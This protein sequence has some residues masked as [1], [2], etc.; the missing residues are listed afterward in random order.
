MSRKKKTAGVPADKGFMGIQLDQTDVS[1]LSALFTKMGV[2]D[3]RMKSI[4]PECDVEPALLAEYGKIISTK[5]SAYSSKKSLTLT[6]SMDRLMLQMIKPSCTFYSLPVEHQVICLLSWLKYPENQK[7]LVDAY[8]VNAKTSRYV[9]VSYDESQGARAVQEALVPLRTAKTRLDNNAPKD[10]VQI[11]YTSAP[12]LVCH[13]SVLCKCTG[14]NR[15][16]NALC[17]TCQDPSGPLKYILSTALGTIDGRIKKQEEALERI[18]G[19]AND[20]IM[21]TDNS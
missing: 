14:R 6:A 20:A 2:S 16:H 3:E 10:I 11:A 1:S 9:E 19:H 15:V 17:S 5:V 21:V 8:N 18:S 7:R 13:E 4:V 12:D